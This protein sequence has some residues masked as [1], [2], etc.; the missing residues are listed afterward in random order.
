[1]RFASL[2]SGSAGNALLVESVVSGR[3]RRLLIDCGFGPRELGRRLGRLGLTAQD[4][5][6]I[7]V[8]HEHGDHVGGV[9]SLARRERLPVYLTW[10]T[11]SAL[12]AAAF[13]DA[14]I[15]LIDVQRGI[16]IAGFGVEPIAVPHD[17]REPVQFVI[18]NGRS[19][20]GV[21][22]D[23]GHGTPHIARAFCRLTALVLECNHDEEMLASGT[24]PPSL[25]RRIS[26][27]YGHLSNTAAGSILAS[28][29]QSQL[30]RVVAAHLSEQNNRPDL[31]AAALLGLGGIEER[32]LMIADQA[33]G[34]DWCAA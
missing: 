11:Y 9:P 10:G 3:A 1:V 26:G 14:P 31:A 12:S 32:L 20:L 15:H 8:T 23:L 7:L 6:A 29:D 16:E 30:A 27:P 17:A 33:G 28:L 4:L 22:T 18:E 5:D 25:K 19:R 2:G 24:Y 34:F 13:G 21:L